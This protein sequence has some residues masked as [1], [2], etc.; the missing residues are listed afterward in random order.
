MKPINCKK[1]DAQYSTLNM[2]R[3]FLIYPWLEHGISILYYI[4]Q[5]AG[6]IY[7]YKYSHIPQLSKFNTTGVCVYTSSRFLCTL[8]S[9]MFG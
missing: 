8:H 2:Y 5:V 9:E 6:T 4:P 3:V 7:K 1:S